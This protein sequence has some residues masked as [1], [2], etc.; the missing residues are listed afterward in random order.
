M[1]THLY[2]LINVLVQDQEVLNQRI[3]TLSA[4]NDELK[5]AASEVAT[6]RGEVNRMVTYAGGYV[7]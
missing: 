3:A 1:F 5:L 6:L 4:E 7:A 2:Y